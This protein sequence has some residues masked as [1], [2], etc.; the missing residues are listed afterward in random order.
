MKFYV[1]ITDGDWYRYLSSQTPLEEVNFRQPSGGRQFRV[2]QPGEPFLFKLH[3][4]Q[5]FEEDFSV[6]SRGSQ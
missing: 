2:L 5:N 4:P 6:P 3:S 1:G